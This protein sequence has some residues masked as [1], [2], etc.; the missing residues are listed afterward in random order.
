MRAVTQPAALAPSRRLAVDLDALQTLL[1]A[2]MSVGS[3]A[4]TLSRSTAWVETQ[5]GLL[6]KALEV[7]LRL[8][9]RGLA[10]IAEVLPIC[11]GR[12]AKTVLLA[13]RIAAGRPKRQAVSLGPHLPRGFVCRTFL[14]WHGGHGAAVAL[15]DGNTAYIESA[16]PLTVGKRAGVALVGGRWALTSAAPPVMV[17]Q[18]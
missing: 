14:T 10:R 12:A 13:A 9:A 7:E 2:K 15:G 17:A 3:I 1:R 5:I 8:A 11:G 16:R 4:R 6:D 18:P